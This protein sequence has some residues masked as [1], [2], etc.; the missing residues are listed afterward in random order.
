LRILLDTCT[1]LW[2]IA[3]AR[4]LSSS[5][6]RAFR[7]EDNE[8][9]L[10][11]ASAWEIALKYS[12]GRLKLADPPALL[13]PK[14]RERHGIEELAVTEADALGAGRLPELH[15]DPFDRLL[16][17]QALA[18]GFQILTPDELIVRY[19]VQTLW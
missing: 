10:S 9:F 13:V 19:P 17:A 12:A 6:R 8:L 11:A 18:R 4:Q 14:Q 7:S 2:L 1:F 3:G 5:A 15:R 16:V